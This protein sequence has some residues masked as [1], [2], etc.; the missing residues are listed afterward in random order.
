MHTRLRATRPFARLR[1]LPVA[2]WAPLLAEM[3]LAL[4]QPARVRREEAESDAEVRR[5]L[6]R[7]G[8]RLLPRQHALAF[9][10]SYANRR[11]TEIARALAMG[12]RLLLLDE[13]TAGMNPTETAEVLDQIKVLRA[14]G[15][16][17]LLIEHKL[18]LV[19]ALSDHVVVLDN[20]KVIAAGPPGAVQDDERVVAAY[21]GRHTAETPDG[22]DGPADL[23]VTSP[24]QVE[25]LP[26]A[27]ADVPAASPLLRLSHVDAFYGPVQAL[28]DVSLHV[29]PGEIVCLLGGNASGKSTTMKVILGLLRPKAGQV[30]MDGAE[31]T[32]LATSDR[33]RRGLA[34]VPEARRVFPEMTVTEN[35]LMGAFLRHD[36]E[37]I[38]ADMERMFA[39]FPRLGERR[40]QLAGTMSGGEQQMLA[41]AR[42]LMSRPR[43]ICM[44]EPTMGLAPVFVERV[45]EAI[46]AINRQG[47]SVF[48]VEQN[49]TLALSIAHRGYVL[50]N[51][52]IVLSG[53]ARDL[54]HNPAIQAAYLGQ[55]AVG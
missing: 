2:R 47:V 31:V 55:R 8:E 7:F 15:Y 39:L 21:L 46:A 43:L 45:L 38:R 53:A 52:G 9:S 28:S 3:G 18:D 10:L 14:E 40:R 23:M 36:G 1:H 34:S 42:A 49:A 51:G 17:I 30:E 20:G 41:M 35:L 32:P 26:N 54:L 4:V 37:G 19:M 6:S 27:V 50:Q 48:M 44:D 25:A 24:A 11:R 33:I 16:T 12:P 5:Q 13:P 29:N 22:V